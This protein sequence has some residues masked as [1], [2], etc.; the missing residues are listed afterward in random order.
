MQTKPQEQVVKIPL[1]VFESAETKEDLED[2]LMA[3]DP[4]FIEEMRKIKS[5][6]EAGS[7]R[8]LAEIAKK[9]N[10]KL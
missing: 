1:A 8:P 2:W 10:I 9:W 3:H 6:A 4:S 7:G 5:D